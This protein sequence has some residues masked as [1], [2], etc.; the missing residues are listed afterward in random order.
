MDTAFLP[1]SLMPTNFAPTINQLR[2]A[3]AISEQI[4]SLEA[5]IAAILGGAGSASKVVGAPKASKKRRKMSPEAREKI[6]AAQRARWANTK[7]EQ[8]STPTEKAAK[9][10]KRGKMSAE[11]RAA[12]VAAQKKR[13]AK[14]KR[15]A[16]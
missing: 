5:E 1:L 14:V 16:K 3:V 6:A 9:K 15:E 8:P 12:I 13:W 11:G 10:K 4:E 2:R 7:G